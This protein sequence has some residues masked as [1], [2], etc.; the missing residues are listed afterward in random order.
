MFISAAK[1]CLAYLDI[2]SYHLTIANVSYSGAIASLNGTR[3]LR[4]PLSRIVEFTL[5]YR[6]L[7]NVNAL[8][9]P[10]R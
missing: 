3:P 10:V 6:C 9:Y 2:P 5:N 8:L 1:I 7:M 4:V